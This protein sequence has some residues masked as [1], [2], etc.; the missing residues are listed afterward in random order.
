MISFKEVLTEAYSFSKYK[1]DE[2]SVSYYFNNKQGDKMF[3]VISNG[4]G[5]D[6]WVD[7][8]DPNVEPQ[9]LEEGELVLD[10]VFG[11]VKGNTWAMN[12][13]GDGLEIGRAHV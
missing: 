8:V 11:N 9:E 7:L 13:S 4:W 12:N 2:D 3:V 1:K 10:I 5:E 6:F